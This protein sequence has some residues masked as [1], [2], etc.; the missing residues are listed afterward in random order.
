VGIAAAL[1]LLVGGIAF[2]ASRKPA[3][4]PSP[5]AKGKSPAQSEKAIRRAT[6]PGGAEQ[7]K[8]QTNPTQPAKDSIRPDAKQEIAVKGRVDG[9]TTA[10]DENGTSTL[11]AGPNPQTR[12][13]PDTRGEPKEDPKTQPTP[14]PKVQTLLA[15][16]KETAFAGYHS[17]GRGFITGK[18]GDPAIEVNGK[19]YPGGLGIHP[20][21]YRVASVKYELMGKWRTFSAVAAIN[22]SGAPVRPLRFTVLGDNRVLWQS[23]PLQQKGQSQRC[24]VDVTGVRLLELQ[25]H[26]PGNFSSAHAVWLDPSVSPAAAPKAPPKGAIMLFDGKDLARWVTRGG[27]PAEWKV[28]NDGSMEVTRG[29]GDIMTKE[30]F[31]PDFRLHVEF[32]LP[33]M[34]KATGQGRANSG[35]YLQGRYEIQVLDSYKNDTYANGSVGALYGIIAPDKEAQEK[36]IRPPEQWQTY[37]IVFHA[38]RVDDQGKVT[39]PGRL[40]VVLN[41]VPIIKGGRFDHVTGGALDERV[42]TPGPLLL[43]DHGCRVRFR[44]IWLVPISDSPLPKAIKKG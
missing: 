31:G 36:A 42:G 9:Q 13:A 25:V 29:K 17:L 38:P 22:D 6:Q 35:V 27:Q 39:N 2:F 37:D 8:L 15:T 10:R 7:P 11:K 12:R 20:R 28:D 5:M 44:N 14:E 1:A 24:N 41:G 33:L 34:E 3:G 4:Q 23:E 21:S 43:Q 18:P 26:C 40:T 16:L 32:W 30:K 19:K